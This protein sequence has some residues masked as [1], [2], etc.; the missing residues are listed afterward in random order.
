MTEIAAEPGND[1]KLCR[2]FEPLTPSLTSEQADLIQ[3]VEHV[4]EGGRKRRLQ[5]LTG[6][7]PH[8][9]LIARA[10]AIAAPFDARVV[11]AYWIANSLLDHVEAGQMYDSLLEWFGKQPRRRTR[12][13]DLGK[14]P[15]GA[16]SPQLPRPGRPQSGR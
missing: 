1:A 10:N 4:V 14:A 5:E 3:A 15:A 9:Q 6:A 2:C 8:L 12:D 16:R 11:R 7:L 13:V